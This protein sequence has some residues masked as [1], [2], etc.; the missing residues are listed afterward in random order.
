MK[1]KR[2][3]GRILVAALVLSAL[4]SLGDKL[5][6][7]SGDQKAD[8]LTARSQV[9]NLKAP[10][11]NLPDTRHIPI[12]GYDGAVFPTAG[13]PIPLL[14][15]AKVLLSGDKAIPKCLSHQPVSN[16]TSARPAPSQ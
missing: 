9:P 8:S 16:S 1:R 10:A 12:G 13:L 7:L 11:G 5:T 6:A 3:L 2:L 4:V 14:T 15:V